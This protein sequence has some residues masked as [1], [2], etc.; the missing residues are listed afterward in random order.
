MFG[1]IFCLLLNEFYYSYSCT[2]IITT[3]FYSISV[4]PPTPNL[5]HLETISFSKCTFFI[6]GFKLKDQPLCGT[7]L[8]AKGK[9]KDIC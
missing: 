9:E 1:V 4:H 3:E 8:M 5:T 7:F 6:L 2:T